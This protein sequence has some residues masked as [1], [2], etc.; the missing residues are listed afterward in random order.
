KGTPNR[1]FALD[2]ARHFMC[3][4]VQEQ[5]TA[6]LGW[7]AMRTDAFGAVQE[8]QQPYFETVRQALEVAQ[9]RPNLTYWPQVEN[10]LSNAFNDV[11]TR[12]APVKDT[13]D[14]YQQEIDK[15]QSAA[16]S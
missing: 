1:D 15:L 8:W 13:L 10:I 9:P 16:S 7:P 5:L 14:R 6:Q 2:F 4:K 11:V 12:G 3:R